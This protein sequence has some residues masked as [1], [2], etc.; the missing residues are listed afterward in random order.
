MV[1]AQAGQ[2]QA[3]GAETFC[4]VMAKVFREFFNL[5]FLGFRP[6]QKFAP[7]IVGIPIQ[8]HFFEPNFFFHADFLFT[9][10][11]NKFTQNGSKMPKDCDT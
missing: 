5:V 3:E 8:L 9:G 1:K 10:E 4:L 6:P 2:G 7:R 11:T